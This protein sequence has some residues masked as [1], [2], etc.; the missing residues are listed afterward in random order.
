MKKQLVLLFLISHYTAFSQSALNVELLAQVDRGDERYS[1][2]WIY[3][4]PDGKE[5][6]LVGAKTG[7]A[8]YQ[9]DDPQHIEELAFI[10]GPVTNWRE[11]TVV[12]DYAYV[13]TDAQ[14]SD[15]AMHVIDLTA[16]PDTAVLINAYTATFTK[17]HIIQRDI[18]SDAP[19]VYVNGTTTTNGVHILDVSDP[20]NPMEIGAYVPGYY[21]HDCHVR[22]DLLFAAA[23]YEGLVDIVD[24]SDRSNP[25][26]I[27][28]FTDPGGNTHSI[29]T[30]A[31]LKYLFLA[32]EQDGL[33][34]RVFDI[35][36][37][38]NP[39]EV[40]TYTAN[41]ASLVHNPY[42]L[43]DFCFIS[44][45]TEGFRVLDIADPV[46][47]VEVGFYD[48]YDGMSGGFSGLWSACPYSESGKIIGGDRTNGLYIW[49]FNNSRAGR[50]YFQVLDSEYG[51]PVYTASVHIN[52]PQQTIF[53]DALG[54]IPFGHLPGQFAATF[55]APLYFPTDV[56]FELIPGQQDTVVVLL[57][58]FPTIDAV[59]EQAKLSLSISPN[60]VQDQV[61]IAWDAAESLGNIRILDMQGKLLF[62]QKVHGQNHCQFNLQHFPSGTYLIEAENTDG[63]IIARETLLL[64]NK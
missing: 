48:T 53:A 6:A 40:A 44:H 62:Q 10:P 57:D 54:W 17:G 52:N 35:S 49:S 56:F 20:W 23:F 61:L 30:T 37:L 3:V 22:G 59:D 38:G 63:K 46:L 18:F 50:V 12:G 14:G 45:N 43:G 28:Q 47:P 16:L 36:D 29:S 9:M 41:S 15:H 19:Y 4:A 7:T 39:Q 25:T 33:P 58:P 34:G 32:D 26:L 24:I 8:I 5:Y 11:I 64:N 60:P 55:E 42:I 1:G 21:I 27:G 51:V 2:S 13:V 31:D